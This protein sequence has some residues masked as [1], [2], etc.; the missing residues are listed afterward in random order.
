MRNLWISYFREVLLLLLLAMEVGAGAGMGVL[1]LLLLAKVGMLLRLDL[2][3]LLLLHKPNDY[4]L[5][6]RFH[7]QEFPLPLLLLL[8]PPLLQHLQLQH[9]NP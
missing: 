3:L 6:A 7:L 4:P 9:F 8:Q 5:V 1:L 2:H